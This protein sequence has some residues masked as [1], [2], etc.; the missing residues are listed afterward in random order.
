RTEEYG[1]ERGQ[2]REVLKVPVVPDESAKRARQ[3][4]AAANLLTQRAAGVH[5]RRGRD[6]LLNLRIHDHRAGRGAQHEG[7]ADEEAPARL[8]PRLVPK[9]VH[10]SSLTL[11]RKISL[12]ATGMTS[13]ETAPAADASAAMS[14]APAFEKTESTRPIRFVRTTPGARNVI[15]GAS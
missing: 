14:S 2:V 1:E 15:A 6:Q 13:T 12:S 5:P 11:S 9:H 3:L 4:D 8:E 10:S 7:H